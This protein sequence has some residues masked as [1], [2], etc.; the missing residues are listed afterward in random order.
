MRC[1]H[2]S[3]AVA[4]NFYWTAHLCDVVMHDVTKRTRDCKRERA[5]NGM[6]QSRARPRRTTA[7]PPTM[8]ELSSAYRRRGCGALLVRVLKYLRW[9]STSL[10]AL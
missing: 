2:D 7:V 4:I 1:K 5:R 9:R 6:Q 8:I 10:R 3:M